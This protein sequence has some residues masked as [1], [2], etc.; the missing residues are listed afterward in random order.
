MALAA[1]CVQAGALGEL[2]SDWI[3]V[4]AVTATL[5]DLDGDG[6][7]ELI[8][9]SSD[10]V[11]VY[12]W[13][14]QDHRY[15]KHMAAGNFPAPI[16]A[17]AASDTSGSGRDDLWVGLRGSGSIQRYTLSEH[18]LVNLGSVGRL[19]SSIRTL[20]PADVDADGLP[21]LLALS[22]AGVTA[23][24]RNE[25]ETFREV[26]RTPPGPDPDRFVAVGPYID[27]PVPTVVIGKS[28]GTVA[29]YQWRTDPAAAGGAPGT[30]TKVF[31]NYP[32]GAIGALDLVTDA[33]GKGQLYV[34]TGQNLLYR[35]TWEKNASVHT[36]LWPQ[37]VMNTGAA[38]QA[39]RVPGLAEQLWLSLEGER[40]QA[41][42]LEAGGLRALWELPDHV[43]WAVQTPSGYLI[44]YAADGLLRVIGP[45]DDT[46]LRVQRGGKGF[47]LSAPALITG[48]E[49]YIAADDLVRVLGLRAWQTR[50]GT[51]L[52]GVAPLFQFFIVD[53]GA[54]NASVNGRARP[55]SSPA[56]VHGGRLYLPVSFAALLGYEYTWVEPIRSLV[57]R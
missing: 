54:P 26:W 3:E 14:P 43:A 31:E 38:L 47:A 7:P 29:V 18:G 25:G 6:T 11:Y 42:R 10:E 27:G 50:Q 45:V 23:L 9:A 57:F 8:V 30:L 2:W 12:R 46:Y 33:A 24:Y 35:Y 19:W 13:H 37:Y 32:W 49:L 53:A 28:Q 15:V 21:D 40:L 5:G 22:E 41:W 16:S 48:G 52:V 55:L 51:R 17:L 44:T 1:P 20:Y 39:L 34:A 56:R 36:G 4:P